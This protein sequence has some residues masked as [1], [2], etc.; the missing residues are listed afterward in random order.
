MAVIVDVSL[1]P[2]AFPIG[3]VFDEHSDLRIELERVVPTSEAPLPYLWLSADAADLTAV[4]ATVRTLPETEVCE[5][6]ATHPDRALY[7][8]RWTQEEDSTLAAIRAAHSGCLDLRGTGDGWE[9]RLR[10]PSSEAVM[11]FNEALTGSGIPVTLRRL[12]DARHPPEH[13]DLSPQ[14][15][16]AIVVAQRRGYFRVPRETS[17]GD[18]SAEVGISNS[19]FSERLRRGLDT[20]IDGLDMHARCPTTI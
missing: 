8:V 2:E 5:R 9:L 11:S 15:C 1:P 6:L 7:H 4:A 18:L 17:I 14:Q 3:R 13:D 19:A 20:L 10:F 16:E 12:N